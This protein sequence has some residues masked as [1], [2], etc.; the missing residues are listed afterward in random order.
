MKDFAYLLTL[1]FFKEP[2]NCY[3]KSQLQVGGDKKVSEAG[4]YT[5]YDSFHLEFI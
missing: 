1:Q 4:L 2:D 5:Y 3:K